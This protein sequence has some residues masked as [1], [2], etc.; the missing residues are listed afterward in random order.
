MGTKSKTK[1]DQ[2]M[3]RAIVLCLCAAAILFSGCPSPEPMGDAG[4]GPDANDHGDGGGSDGG[5]RTDGGTDGGSTQVRLRGA[6][7]KGPFVTGSTVTVGVLDAA[8][9][10]PNGT[11]Y[12]TSTTSDL[13]EF[14]LLLPTLA[15]IQIEG[16]G[17]YFNE[18][19][20]ALSTAPIVLRA[21][22]V[23]GAGP[24]QTAHVNMITH[25]TGERVRTLVS[26]GATFADAVM[27]A[28][29]ELETQLAITEPS[30]DPHAHGVDL[31]IAGGDTDANAYLFGV[32]A[33]LAYTASLRTPGSADANLQ[34]LV[35]V[36]TLDL[37]DDGTLGASVVSEI[38][39]ALLQLST[40]TIEDAF[41]A[42]LL[43]VGSSASVPDLDRVL[44][45]DGDGLA[46]AHD[47]CPLVPNADQADDDGDGKG[48]ACD[49]C[50]LTACAADCIPA[51]PP[52][53]TVDLCI[54]RCALGT[55][56][57]AT[58][59]AIC[60]ATMVHDLVDPTGAGTSAYLCAGGCMPND[61]STCGASEY[62]G[63]ARDDATS[64]SALTWRCLP[65]LAAAVEGTACAGAGLVNA[66]CAHGLVCDGA[67]PDVLGATATCLFDGMDCRVAL[68]G[69]CRPACGAGTL[70]ACGAGTSCVDGIPP[71][72]SPDFTDPVAR[73]CDVFGLV[74]A[75][76]AAR[77]CGAGLVC[78]QASPTPYCD[79][80]H[81]VGEP[82]IDDAN[83][84]SG[85]CNVGARVCT[86]GAIGDGCSRPNQCASGFCSGATMACTTGDVG[87]PCAGG[88]RPGECATALVCD[89]ATNVCATP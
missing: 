55:E 49:A 60:V 70:P 82:C 7:E 44:D 80:P 10:A 68:A 78:L 58:T 77:T 88:G 36:M 66:G 71:E 46:N 29:T 26:G 73:V 51:A 38:H 74:G 31:T 9:L 17:F 47:D 37:R 63:L 22:Y 34:E 89:G 33:T 50:P 53:L 48:N 23:P 28:E 6:V 64:H 30:F 41:S 72:H 32:S 24:T 27:Q 59:G 2:G 43:A 61:P 75:S 83:C 56:A 21:L 81:A 85:Y 86:T 15:P 62:C 39:A 54:E 13:G 14:T 4:G 84:T 3:R 40:S 5:G 65:A 25:L 45:Q 8:T 12:T 79:A 16:S 69:A 20:G 87:E 76:C 57:C 19:V 1:H 11:T 67:D 42:R 35:N 52:A 18:A